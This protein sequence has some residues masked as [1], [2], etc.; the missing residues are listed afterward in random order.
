MQTE[1]STMRPCAIA[2][3]TVAPIAVGAGCWRRD[4]PARAGV[5]LW[6]VDMAP[7]AQWPHLDRHDQGGE[8]VLVLSGELIDGGVRHGPGTYLNF[9]PHSAHQ[10]RT[11]TGVRLFGV[12]LAPS[13][14]SSTTTAALANDAGEVA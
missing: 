9:A 5:R 2:V 14:E 10:P 4:L 12:N 1:P 6:I 11:D 7:G 8:D 3:D 13:S